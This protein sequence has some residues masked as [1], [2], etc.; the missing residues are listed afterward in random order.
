MSTQVSRHI[1]GG[2]VS[3]G[4][5]RGPLSEE[6]A[7]GSPNQAC[8]A[9][10]PHTKL[11]KGS[12]VLGKSSLLT[13]LHP[14]C[15][16]ATNMLCCPGQDTKCLWALVLQVQKEGDELGILKASLSARFEGSFHISMTLPVSL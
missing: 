10:A 5:S 11:I 16:P 1:E 9:G 6:L 2:V 15:A 14:S 8:S 3:L 4:K 13:D 7:L 12:S